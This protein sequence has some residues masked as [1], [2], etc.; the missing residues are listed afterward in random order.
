MLKK[1]NK[2][3]IL[4]WHSLHQSR[5]KVIENYRHF[6]DFV[7][8]KS[9]FM[10]QQHHLKFNY[11]MSSINKIMPHLNSF[12]SSI[13]LIMLSEVIVGKSHKIGCMCDIKEP[14]RAT[15]KVAMIDPH[16]RRAKNRNS[17]S[18]APEPM[19]H[20]VRAAP[21][22]PGLPGLA[23]VD[24]K[25]VDYHVAHALYSDARPVGYLDPGPPPIDGLITIHDQL[26][27]KGNHHVAFEYD[28]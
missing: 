19:P 25:P 6:H 22:Q 20:V 13:Y 1:Q 26:I 28:P 8:C 9:I 18:I 3:I 4:P 21:H 12:I 5:A 23:V 17:I 24:A 16:I 7:I 27:F 15:S 2:Y 14:I 11:T 10:S